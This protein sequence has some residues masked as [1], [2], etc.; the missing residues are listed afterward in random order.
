MLV[1]FQVT[2][3]WPLEERR[4]DEMISAMNTWLHDRTT[5]GLFSRHVNVSCYKQNVFFMS[6]LFMRPARQHVPHDDR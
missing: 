5:T 4:D 1:L 2:A 3:Y 6:L